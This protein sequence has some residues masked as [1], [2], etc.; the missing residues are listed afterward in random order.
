M[1]I[2]LFLGLGRQLLFYDFP[3]TDDEVLFGK[4]YQEIKRVLYIGET[5]GMLGD[6]IPK[7]LQT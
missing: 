2:C 7:F 4:P 1:G 5:V 6:E 3:F